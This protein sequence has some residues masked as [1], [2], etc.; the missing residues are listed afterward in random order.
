MTPLTAACVLYR[1]SSSSQ[2]LRRN[3][4]AAPP[5]LSNGCAARLAPAPSETASSI[6][7]QQRR[8]LDCDCTS[9]NGDSTAH[10]QAHLRGTAEMPPYYR[11]G[12]RHSAL[13]QPRTAWRAHL[14]KTQKLATQPSKLDVLQH[15]LTQ[16][17]N[18]F[19]PSDPAP[20][21][22]QQQANRRCRTGKA[23]ASTLVEHDGA[24]PGP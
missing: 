15:L 23:V 4:L 8:H 20:T 14:F 10:H 19:P 2:P 7:K 17:S 12:R 18:A 1:R 22:T 16:C 21:R 13:R 5:S 11:A 3:Q 9:K 6:T 24:R